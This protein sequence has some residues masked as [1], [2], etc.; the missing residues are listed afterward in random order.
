MHRS[1]FDQGLERIKRTFP[2]MDDGT[3]EEVERRW[4]GLDAILWKAMCQWVI[5]NC[6]F[7]PKPAKFKEA[8]ASCRMSWRKDTLAV[9]KRDCPHCF[10]SCGFNWVYY[11]ALRGTP[12]TGIVPCKMCNPDQR[13]PHPEVEVEIERYITADEYDELCTERVKNVVHRNPKSTVF[14]NTMEDTKRLAGQK[15]AQAKTMGPTEDFPF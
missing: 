15:L 12:Y 10:N 4:M 1:D 5:E 7:A 8:H 9:K 2:K 11:T 6:T 14:R 13:L 3:I